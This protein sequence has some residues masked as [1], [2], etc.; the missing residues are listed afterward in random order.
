MENLKQLY[1]NM[2]QL[3]VDTEIFAIEHNHK[4]LSCIFIIQDYG[5]TLF[6]TTLER[7]PRTFS[8]DIPSDFSAPNHIDSEVYPI[9]AQYFGFTGKTGNRFIPSIFFEEIDKKIPV[10]PHQQATP[11]QKVRAIGMAANTSDGDGRFFLRM[12][13]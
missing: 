3:C 1:N 12:A 4:G 10:Y 7:D 6:L 11:Q 8:V 13:S 5:S 9:L 2:N